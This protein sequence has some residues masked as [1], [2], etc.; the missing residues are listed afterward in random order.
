MYLYQ[1]G[2][3]NSV[4]IVDIHAAMMIPIIVNSVI[5]I[6]VKAVLLIAE[7]AKKPCALIV[8]VSVVTARHSYVH[9]VRLNVLNVM[10]T[11]VK[12]V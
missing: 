7:S 9:A 8:A 5:M 2:M 1:I 12:I 4:M 3:V 11:H 10:N 6:T